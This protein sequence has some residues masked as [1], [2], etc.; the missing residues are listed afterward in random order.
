MLRNKTITKFIWDHRSPQIAKAIFRKKNKARGTT[1]SDFKLYY[2]FS[3]Y[4]NV[5]GIKTGTDQGNRIES[6]EINSCVY[7]K[8]AKNTH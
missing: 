6:P 3:G 8:G 7:D 5:A 4:N 2:S 1:F